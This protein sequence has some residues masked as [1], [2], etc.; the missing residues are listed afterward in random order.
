M[1]FIEWE[2]N[3]ILQI[4]IDR[5]NIQ[6]AILNEKNDISCHLIDSDKTITEYFYN[7][8]EKVEYR[9]IILSLYKDNEIKYFLIKSVKPVILTSDIQGNL[10]NCNLKCGTISEITRNLKIYNILN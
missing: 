5:L 10:S 4:N 3:K 6:T 9:N 8:Q 7:W 2:G 1:C